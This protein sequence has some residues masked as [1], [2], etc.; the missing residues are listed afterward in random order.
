MRWFLQAS[1]S[2]FSDPRLYH[3]LLHILPSPSRFPNPHHIHYT[4]SSAHL[5]VPC[6]LP[7]ISKFHTRSFSHLGI[8]RLRTSIL[9]THPD[10]LS[11]LVAVLLHA[12]LPTAPHPTFSFP[13]VLQGAL[14]LFLRRLLAPPHL[15]P[16]T[17]S[18]IPCI[19]L[20]T[21]G[22]GNSVD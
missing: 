18:S 11:L 5:G 22:S 9:I 20:H 6:I 12:H 21:R 2:N 1:V 17:P 15:T 8:A 14:K 4:G 13:Q 16:P 7:G 19:L 3:L 10:F